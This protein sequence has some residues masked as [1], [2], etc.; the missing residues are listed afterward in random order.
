M[1]QHTK[2]KENLKD[3]QK[4]GRAGEVAQQLGTLSAL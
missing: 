2:T 1:S 4:V 3:P